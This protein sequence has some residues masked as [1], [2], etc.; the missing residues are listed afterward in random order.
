[1]YW[2]EATTSSTSPLAVQLE[3]LKKL[4]G[5]GCASV[6]VGRLTET[7][8]TESRAGMEIFKSDT[9]T[10]KMTTMARVTLNSSNRPRERKLR[11]LATVAAPNPDQA[12]SV[13]LRSG[14]RGMLKEYFRYQAHTDLRVFVL[15][16]SSLNQLGE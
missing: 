2:R 1:M 15:Y 3:E 5:I 13:S 11:M 12:R 4:P 6:V 14:T 8:E 10:L 7:V 9:A 16:Y